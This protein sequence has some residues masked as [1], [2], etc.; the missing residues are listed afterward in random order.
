MTAGP[1]ATSVRA[2]ARSDRRAVDE[3]R[4]ENPGQVFRGRDIERERDPL[5]AFGVERAEI[6][7]KI[8]RAADEAGDLLRRGGDRGRRAGGEQ[9]VGGIS[10]RH[11]VGDAVNARI[12]CANIIAQ[13]R[14]PFDDG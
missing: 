12:F 10:L 11:S 7:Q 8:V 14:C 6:H 2:K 5:A 4:I 13:R 3:Y 1:R 9:H